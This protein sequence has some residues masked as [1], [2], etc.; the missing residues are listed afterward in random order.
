MRR[1]KST[2]SRA[3]IALLSLAVVVLC[4]L[5]T[6][7]FQLMSKQQYET[8][9]RRLQENADSLTD[10]LDG[11][12]YDY[13]SYANV[14]AEASALR[15][16]N[17]Y[18]EDPV[19][20]Q[21]NAIA[22]LKSFKELDPR[23]VSLSMYYHE[24]DYFITDAALYRQQSFIHAFS[25]YTQAD[26]QALYQQFLDFSISDSETARAPR[27][28]PLGNMQN[29]AQADR[30]QSILLLLLPV[31]AFG[32]R[33]YATL[34][35]FVKT[36]D[37]FHQ[38]S[39]AAGE[40]CA[41]I[42][43]EAGETLFSVGE[44]KLP[45]GGTGATEIITLSSPSQKFCITYEIIGARRMLS[46]ANVNGSQ[47]FVILAVIAVLAGA[48]SVLFAKWVNQPIRNLTADLS[49]PDTGDD[50]AMIRQHINK[51]SQ[52]AM[53][54]QRYMDELLIRR[55]VS[56]QII[57]DMNTDSFIQALQ[58]DYSHCSVF[59][60]Q[61]KQP[62]ASPFQLTELRYEHAMVH[63]IQGMSMNNLLGIIAYDIPES[64]VNGL[65][66]QVLAE[67]NIP[68]V[69]AVAI[70]PA[71][72]SVEQLS[73][74]YQNARD[75]LKEMQYQGRGGIE[76]YSADE[77]PASIYPVESMYQMRTALLERNPVLL[78]DA[79]AAIQEALQSAGITSDVGGIVIC[80]LT[81]LFPELKACVNQPIWQFCHALQC[82]VQKAAREMESTENAQLINDNDEQWQ[83]GV[84]QDIEAMLESPG[85]GISMMAA[86][87]MVSD[88]AFSHR[89]KRSFGLTFISY[90]NNEKIRRAKEYL[91]TTDMNL[92]AI[93]NR[94]GYSS[95]SNFSRM[96]KSTVGIPPSAY[97]HISQNAARP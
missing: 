15:P 17:L 96:F 4:V 5:T 63:V 67:K 30:E 24:K 36:A 95:S 62:L 38:L 68:L 49:I 51:L 39:L 19:V 77:K 88:S 3:V 43:N 57:E 75:L 79:C 91:Q 2:S 1:F 34:G 64:Y 46:R 83:A 33:S 14:I 66:K 69:Q 58:A 78:E 60:M 85:F 65:L 94:L 31:P 81:V 80:D 48:S 90:V 45:K 40:G 74:S 35:I 97:R 13:Y 37:I 59:M 27:F 22:Q 29:T 53:E 86:K 52:Q 71:K 92:E 73:D 26:T 23:I 84:R 70:G 8:N 93:A 28:V 10:L 47:L 32:N 21:M 18:R 12:F 42:L 61:L 9:L 25:S 55:M 54:K 20:S 76:L 16:L 6:G 41:R 7:F 82:I 89:F 87:Y 50:A 44:E 11:F 72:E 56:G